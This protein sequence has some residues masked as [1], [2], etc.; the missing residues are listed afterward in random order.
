MR[1]LSSIITL[2]RPVGLGPFTKITIGMA[3]DHFAKTRSLTASKAQ[4]QIK[5]RTDHIAITPCPRHGPALR[6]RELKR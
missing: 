1:R 6:Q 4:D 3:K 5:R 2:S